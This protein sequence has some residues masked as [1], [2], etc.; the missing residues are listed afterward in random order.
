LRKITAR[1]SLRNHSKP[2]KRKPGVE[3]FSRLATI[4]RHHTDTHARTR[5]QPVSQAELLDG[6][7]K[8]RSISTHTQRRRR[9]CGRSLMGAEDRS[10]VKSSAAEMSLHGERE[11]TP[12]SRAEITRS[13]VALQYCARRRRLARKLP[14]DEPPPPPPE[15]T[16][17]HVTR[18]SVT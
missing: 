5:T 8:K 14:G 2:R 15:M 7:L 18:S 1:P 3:P 13:V 11:T 6:Q 10:V 9:E 16:S 12:V 17:L 4:H